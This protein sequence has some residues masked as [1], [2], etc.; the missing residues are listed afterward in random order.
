MAT[1]VAS[2][3]KKPLR[4]RRND[5]KLDHR[6]FLP[7]YTTPS[8]E[9]SMQQANDTATFLIK[10]NALADL[11]TL[12]RPMLA[13]C[14][15]DASIPLNPYLHAPS[16]AKWWLSRVQSET[17]LEDGSLDTY[18]DILDV[19][20]EKLKMW[21]RAWTSGCGP[22][23]RKG[24][25]KFLDQVHLYLSIVSKKS[26]SGI[27]DVPYA[28][29]SSPPDSI[30]SQGQS[31]A[32]DANIKED[33]LNEDTP[34]NGR[35]SSEEEERRVN[36][37]SL[38][39]YITVLVDL[40][41]KTDAFSTVDISRLAAL[42]E[43]EA[44]EPAPIE[45]WSTYKECIEDIEQDLQ[46]WEMYWAN[47]EGDGNGEKTGRQ[48]FEQCIKKH[49]PDKPEPPTPTNEGSLDDV[50]RDMDT[51]TS[52][53]RKHRE[54]GRKTLEA[55]LQNVKAQI[56]IHSNLQYLDFRKIAEVWERKV[57][58]DADIKTTDDLIE[59]DEVLLDEGCLIE[60]HS[61]SWHMYEF[62]GLT[63]EQAFYERFERYFGDINKFI[64]ESAD[65]SENTD[66][67][68][69][70]LATGG[71]ERDSDS[72]SG[73]DSGTDADGEYE[74]DDDYD[75]QLFPPMFGSRTVF[76]QRTPLDLYNDVE[77]SETLDDS[78]YDDIY[79]YNAEYTNTNQGEDVTEGRAY[80]EFDHGVQGV[81]AELISPASP[82]QEEQGPSGSYTMSNDED[83]PM[84]HS[85]PLHGSDVSYLPMLSQP[86][87]GNVSF[88]GLDRADGNDSNAENMDFSYV[89]QSATISPFSFPMQIPGINMMPGSIGTGFTPSMD[90]PS[91]QEDLSSLPRHSYW[92]NDNDC[93][94]DIDV[95]KDA[96][97]Q[98]ILVD[99]LIADA[100][101]RTSEDIH[102]S[103]GNQEVFGQFAQQSNPP[104][105]FHLEAGK[106]FTY[107]PNWPQE[108]TN[109]FAALGLASLLPATP[110]KPLFGSINKAPISSEGIQAS[111]KMCK[112]KLAVPA[113]DRDQDGMMED[114]TQAEAPSHMIPAESTDSIS[115]ERELD[116][117][118]Q[119]PNDK[120][121]LL[122]P[123]T[124]TTLFKVEGM[125]FSPTTFSQG[126]S[127]QPFAKI[128]FANTADL[129]SLSRTP[130]VPEVVCE[131]P[132]QTPSVCVEEPA[133]PN[134]AASEPATEAE[135]ATML[136]E[137]AEEVYEGS[138]DRPGE[139]FEP[140]AMPESVPEQVQ[141]TATPSHPQ[142]PSEVK[143]LHLIIWACETEWSSLAISQAIPRNF[144]TM[145][146]S[147]FTT[148]HSTPKTNDMLFRK[149]LSIL[150]K[151]WR[152]LFKAVIAYHNLSSGFSDAEQASLRTAAANVHDNDRTA[153]AYLKQAAEY[154]RN[155]K[156]YT[157]QRL[158]T[159]AR[160]RA[161]HKEELLSVN[162]AKLDMLV[163]HHQEYYHAL[164][165]MLGHFIDLDKAD[166]ELHY[167]LMD[168]TL[169]DYRERIEDA[170]RSFG[171][172][173]EELA[174]DVSSFPISL[175]LEID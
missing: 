88:Q 167:R 21:T 25:D 73:F 172:R 133:S 108:L 15:Q 35:L 158:E 169:V 8:E 87:V 159:M 24:R 30:G 166:T 48:L 118:V 52:A 1:S 78:D 9:E 163:Q 143:K 98:A 105:Q 41:P 136:S 71:D 54:E 115:S 170:H 111:D 50:A 157:A 121:S 38:R 13:K 3:V 44:R 42:L 126:P 68:L 77:G 113:S 16:I 175:A 6:D 138:E 117:K 45:Q 69:Y 125:L 5:V 34:Q 148:Y 112:V 144:Q 130:G 156:E 127:F 120:V 146:D 139:S 106:P 20:L 149:R 145:A 39:S 75:S 155:G 83:V 173:C 104:I 64:D 135:D 63:G 114:V 53:I 36:R 26:N 79:N 70:A 80:S 19:D 66:D 56:P 93:E 95:E 174:V 97:D 10:N 100:D 151:Q 101:A 122:S 92:L 152:M 85:E 40:M 154:R 28:K 33:L 164:Q 96:H 153:Q 11:E 150:S 29:S 140:A 59:Y 31:L 43:T 22:D 60:E 67:E 94:M 14:F 65:H 102:M 49:F 47:T 134:V 89:Q 168:T 160:D 18:L 161:R 72:E 27:L 2:R 17:D 51:K 119:S 132:A 55:C 4:T 90:P 12:I 124:Q 107:Q 7:K 76:P 128:D 110:P 91:N 171:V 131:T 86:V 165:D 129:S 147:L 99:L 81:D 62:K 58:Q 162:T 37:K 116:C 23:K 141:T 123:P 103:E 82:S 32:E 74:I 84:E 109:P 57:W 46:D 137:G 61:A 142:E